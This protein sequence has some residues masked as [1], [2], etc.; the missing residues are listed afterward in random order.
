MDQYRS[1]EN[2]KLVDR[3]KQPLVKRA[4]KALIGRVSWRLP[5]LA[6]AMEFAS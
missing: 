1:M 3:Q 4:A 2:K 6:F 5:V